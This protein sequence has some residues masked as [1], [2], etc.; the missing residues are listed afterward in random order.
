MSFALI[1]PALLL[2]RILGEPRH[3]HPLIGFGRMAHY[4][5]KRLNRRSGQAMR[6]T[7]S[8]AVLLLVT[9]LALAAHGLSGWL[10]PLFDIL[11]L[12]LAIGANSLAGHA[13]AVAEAL[14]L[15]DPDAA[16][17]RVG[18]IVSR[19]TQDMSH[20]AIV[21]ATLESVL[22]NGADAIFA[23]LFWFLLAGAPGVVVYRLVN[24]LDAMWGYRTPRFLDF[25]WS[26][27]RLDDLLNWLPARLTALAYAVVGDWRGSIRCWREQ[28]GALDS[29][30]AGV[31]MT[32][33]AGALGVI[34]GGPCCYAGLVKNKPYFGT[35]VVP[36]TGD[37]YRAIDLVQ[38]S[39]LLWV[40]GILLGG[41]LL[42]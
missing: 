4:L 40:I 18:M 24:T 8:L 12:Y 13:R 42:A 28:A 25:G 3:W 34:L 38:K 26:A 10:G 19:D 32:A 16:R 7:G 21:S 30:N 11:L 31:V 15:P 36:V 9:P 27:A 20:T 1:L 29:P 5:E 22:E 41:W 37:I 33:G 35:G 14:Q 39:L 17:E 6:I 2:D 23:A